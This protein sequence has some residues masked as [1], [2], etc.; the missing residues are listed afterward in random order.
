MSSHSISATR[1]KSRLLACRPPNRE[2]VPGTRMMSPCFPDIAPHFCLPMRLLPVFFTDPP[3]I[4]PLRSAVMA[5]R[6][7]RPRA[8]ANFCRD[9][10]S[11]WFRFFNC[12]LFLMAGHTPGP[13]TGTSELRQFPMIL[14]FRD[15]LLLRGLNF[16]PVYSPSLLDMP[17]SLLAMPSSYF[18][19]HS[20]WLPFLP[21]GRR[22]WLAFISAAMANRRS[23]IGS[24]LSSILVG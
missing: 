7:I 15:A 17:L 24:V 18:E 5:L 14:F 12:P 3:Q 20:F 19:R 8:A 22:S 16:S 9:P 23:V 4:H 11:P 13:Q 21:V 6:V 2:F 1:W 10:P